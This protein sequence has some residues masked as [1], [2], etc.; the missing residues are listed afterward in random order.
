MELRLCFF[1]R[2]K[3]SDFG[4]GPAS[5]RI[6]AAWRWALAS[7]SGVNLAIAGFGRGGY[8]AGSLDPV[9]PRQTVGAGLYFEGHHEMGE[10]IGERAPVELRLCFPKMG[11]GE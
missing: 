1:K 8:F 3:G 9:G 2:G 4:V 5:I 10:R 11:K 7:C 6:D